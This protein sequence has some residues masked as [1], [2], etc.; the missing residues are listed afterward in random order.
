MDDLR[1]LVADDEE[2]M[3]GIM[4]KIIQ[5]VDGFTVVGEAEDGEDA[6]SKVESLKPDVVFLDVE[7]PK[8]NGIDC[9][10]SIQDMNPFITV[11]FA[12]A[13]DGYMSDAFE[14]YAFDYLVKPFKME[15]VIQTLERIRDRQSKREEPEKE[16]PRAI[17]A[18][19]KPISG[20]LMLR[21]REGVSFVDLN[22]ILLIQRE[23]RQAGHADGHAEG[24]QHDRQ[25]RL[26]QARRQQVG[27]GEVAAGGEDHDAQGQGDGP[28][29]R[30]L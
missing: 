15:R 7:M 3:R 25:H 29:R 16:A 18:D 12:T 5:K 8:I 19:R 13:Y 22:D 28:R 6:L 30:Q 21:H 17:N 26:G 10:R 27:D 2:I 23:E 4:R 14:V 1:V 9:A 11:I 20:R 24:V